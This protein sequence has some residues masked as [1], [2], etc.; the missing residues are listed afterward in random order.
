MSYNFLLLNPDKTEV[1][2]LGP[3]PIRESLSSNIVNLDGIALDSSTTVRNLAVVFNQELS[4]NSYFTLILRVGL[5]P[6]FLIKLI[7]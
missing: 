4:F 7:V 6:S 3:K 5:K 1:I 2:L